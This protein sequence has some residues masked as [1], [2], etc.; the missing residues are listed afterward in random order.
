M[1]FN[2]NASS[3]ISFPL[4]GIGS[5][6]IGLAGNGRLIDW[7]I[8]NHANKGG[9]NGIS[10]FAVRAEEN[11]KVV[12]IRVLN[13]DLPP[14]YIGDY[15]QTVTYNGYGYGPVV[16]SLANLPHFSNH[17]FEGAYPTAKIKFGGE[18]FPAEVIILAV[19]HL[20]ECYWH[21]LIFNMIGI[22]E[23]WGLLRKLREIFQVFGHWVMYGEHLKI[24][25][26]GLF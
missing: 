17:T 19:W 11:G 14:H 12:D 9:Y 2:K 10:H 18:K 15:K 21:F 23:F 24:T 20:M 25:L 6:S 22:T 16:G 1:I 4:G 8:F 13:G 3:A 7:E 5:G 26:Q